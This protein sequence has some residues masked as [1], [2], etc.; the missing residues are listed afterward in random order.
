M[1]KF[2]KPF[3][4]ISFLVAFSLILGGTFFLFF[5][6]NSNQSLASNSTQSSA[7]N[8]TSLQNSSSVFSSVSSQNSIKIQ[9]LIADE[10]HDVVVLD[11]CDLAVRFSKKIKI[12]KSQDNDL[13][14]FSYVFISDKSNS[15]NAWIRCGTTN[16]NDNL[17]INQSLE[18]KKNE[19]FRYFKLEGY[20]LDKN[21]IT[22]YLTDY[23]FTAVSKYD[24]V[25]EFATT[26]G[27]NNLQ[28]ISLKNENDTEINNKWVTYT[29]KYVFLDKKI[30]NF[31]LT[32]QPNSLAPSTPSVKL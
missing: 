8:S 14:Y 29:V 2:S 25:F 32:L 31:D 16:S 21:E 17:A 28:S 13:N 6:K 20:I 4:I 19:I 23:N 3:V 15:E 12:K 22:K 27:I 7:Q 18:E 1:L 26:I 24:M 11:E 9:P 10:T 30:K 5:Q